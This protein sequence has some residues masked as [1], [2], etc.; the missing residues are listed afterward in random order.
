MA[1]KKDITGPDEV[2]RSYHKIPSF[3]VFL[4]DD[5]TCQMQIITQNWTTADARR[6]NS[7][8]KNY[9]HSIIGL[10]SGVMQIAYTMLKKYFSEYDDGD[11]ML[12]DDWKN[13]I[14]Q[15]KMT[16]VSQTLEGKL[17]DKREVTDDTDTVQ[18][19]G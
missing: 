15:S 13:K 3:T 19:K 5:G 8:A 12:V 18:N 11:D 17:L 4:N 9:Q 14:G 6:R 1:I 7:E 10:P 16:L 2:V